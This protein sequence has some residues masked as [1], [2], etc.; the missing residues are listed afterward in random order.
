MA[1]NPKG[2]DHKSAYLIG[3]GLAAPTAACYLLRDGKPLSEMDLGFLEKLAAKKFL[4]KIE[5][6]DI[7]KLLDEYHVI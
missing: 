5:D 2:V 6:T 3:T 7:K 1:A 4:G